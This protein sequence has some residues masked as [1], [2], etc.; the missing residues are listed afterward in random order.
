MQENHKIEVSL[1]NT[2]ILRLALTTQVDQFKKKKQKRVRLL[3]KYCIYQYI[4]TTTPIFLRAYILRRKEIQSW[5][6]TD[7]FCSSSDLHPR[8]VLFI[9][10]GTR[11][12]RLLFQRKKRNR[13]IW[14]FLTSIN[15]EQCSSLPLIGWTIVVFSFITINIT[16]TTVETITGLCGFKYYY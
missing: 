4:Q 5:R 13:N 6:I 2:I 14:C 3:A 15:T 7:I 8:E 9:P 1:S 10:Q 12:K 11:I 16:L